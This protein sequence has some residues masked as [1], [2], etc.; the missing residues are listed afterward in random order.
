METYS[1]HQD[2][3]SLRSPDKVVWVTMQRRCAVAI[4]LQGQGQWTDVNNTQLQH[5][6]TKAHLLNV[7]CASGYSEQIFEIDEQHTA[8]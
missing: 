1:Q 5:T 4:L 3:N 7:I 6:A 8:L 2:V